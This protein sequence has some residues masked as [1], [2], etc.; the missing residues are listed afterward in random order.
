[1]KENRDILNQIDRRDGMTVPT[2]YFD[3]FAANMIQDLPL[4]N[5]AENPQAVILPP[6]T[7]WSRIRPYVYL[8]AMFA[9]IWCML[10]M[11]TLM[12]APTDTGTVIDRNPV[13]AEAI[14]NDV[15]IRD[16][17]IDDINQWDL[18]DEMIDDGFDASYLDM[19]EDSDHEV[20]FIDPATSVPEI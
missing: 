19:V 9:G 12:S 13:L 15:F 16:Y 2:G 4:R 8:A 3:S 6:P 18:I 10:K 20:S 14:G 7:L 11:F 17:V 1:M 5:E